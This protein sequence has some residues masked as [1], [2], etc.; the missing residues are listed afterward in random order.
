MQVSLREWDTYSGVFE[1]VVDGDVQVARDLQVVVD[2]GPYQHA[3][4]EG[5]FPEADH[6]RRRSGTLECFRM[7][8]RGVAEYFQY[9]L[10]VGAEGDVNENFDPARHVRARP[11]DEL[12]GHEVAVRYDDLGAI[13][14]PDGASADTDAAHDSEM[15]FR[16]DAIADF[17]WSFEN[18]NETGNEIA[19]DV[20]E[21]EADA[22]SQRAEND[23]EL[24]PAQPTG[25]CRQQHS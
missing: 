21:A 23:G 5:A 14:R 19:H 7:R 25:G 2:P 9:F 11:V 17:D 24:R 8:A 16:F 1:L 15:I 3:E 18:Q 20:L 4:I 22:D 10:R 12:F 6:Q 13:E